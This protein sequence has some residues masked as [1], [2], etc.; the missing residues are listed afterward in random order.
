MLQLKN[1]WYP[2]K[3]VTTAMDEIASTTSEGANSTTL[4]AQKTEDVASKVNEIVKQAE[5]S[6]SS[7]VKL[8]K[9]LLNSKYKI[10]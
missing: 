1:S 9:W 3:N 4:I 6:K 5:A 7:S 10:I 2:S 8:K